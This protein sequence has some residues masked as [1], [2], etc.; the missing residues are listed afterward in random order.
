M[1]SNQEETSVDREL[2]HCH[3]VD[4]NACG[5]E[6]SGSGFALLNDHFAG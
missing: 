5:A 3:S 1:G 6:G 2:S 4:E